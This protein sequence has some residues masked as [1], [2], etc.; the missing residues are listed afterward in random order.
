MTDPH[1]DRET[2]RGTADPERDANGRQ[3]DLIG[4]TVKDRGPDKDPYWNRVG[5]AWRHRDG[6]GLDL[7]LDATPVDG[8]I[9]LRE[10]RREEFQEDRRQADAPD[11]DRN[12][13]R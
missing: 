10:Q 1:D 11:R 8:R 6:K 3:P 13:S 9:T 12:R 4:Y 2:E 5:A 7:H